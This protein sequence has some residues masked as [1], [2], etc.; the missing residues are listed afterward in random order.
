MVHLIL[1]SIQIRPNKISIFS[2]IIPKLNWKWKM[3]DE[4]S[5]SNENHPFTASP[6]QESMDAFSFADSL[7]SLGCSMRDHFIKSFGLARENSSSS[8]QNE[9]SIDSITADSNLLPN[10]QAENPNIESPE[11]PNSGDITPTE[12]SNDDDENVDKSGDINF[13]SK[14]AHF[15]RNTFNIRERLSSLV[16]LVV[17]DFTPDPTLFHSDS[18]PDLVDFFGAQRGGDKFMDIYSVKDITNM[19]QNS[20]LSA[21]LEK[22]GYSDWYIEFDLSDC[23]MH[24]GYLRSK[25][26]PEADKF[27]GFMIVQKGEFRLKSPLAADNTPGISFVH[28]NFPHGCNMLNIR[29]FA[30]QNPRAHFSSKKPRLPGQRFPGSGLARE[31]FKIFCKSAIKNGR[32]GIVNVPEHFHNA[33]LYENFV[34]MNP[35]DQGEFEKM[36]NDLADDIKEKGLAAVSWAIYLGFLRKDDEVAKWEPREQIFPLS[37]KLI[38]YFHKLGFKAIVEEKKK[39]K[40]RYHIM[41]DEAEGYCLTAVIEFSSDETAYAPTKP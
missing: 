15:L 5:D 28:G 6:S 2:N 23:F 1:N 19:I 35:E 38:H 37:I 39:Q 40:A 14:I 17:P 31:C 7:V 24:Y 27:I 18:N 3:T 33:L 32:D 12:K 10:Q 30:L 20:P 11:N 9:N 21:S 41:W 36:K 29:W 16:D 22:M 34:F 13:T 26:I 25:S 4:N 8:I